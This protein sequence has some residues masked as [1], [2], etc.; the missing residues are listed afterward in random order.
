MV[1]IYIIILKYD[2]M[3]TANLYIACAHGP[4]YNK[5]GRILGVRKEL[6]IRKENQFIPIL[7]F[8]EAYLYNPEEPQKYGVP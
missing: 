7:W 6:I 8:Q 5:G 2:Q 4:P 3:Q 1:I